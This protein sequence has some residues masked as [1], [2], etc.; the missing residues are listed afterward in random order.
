[1][2]NVLN[3]VLKRISATN[4]GKLLDSLVPN[5]TGMLITQKL[6]TQ[7]DPKSGITGPQIKHNRTPN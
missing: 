1:M 2:M 3:T 7:Q 4:S 5:M 6:S